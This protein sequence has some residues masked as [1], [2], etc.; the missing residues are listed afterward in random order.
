MDVDHLVPFVPL[1]QHFIDM[2]MDVAL[3]RL[4]CDLELLQAIC[5]SCHDVKT[6]FENKL[7][8]KKKRIKNGKSS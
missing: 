7:R 4:F 1:D 2:S 8:P 5:E 3:G 6:K